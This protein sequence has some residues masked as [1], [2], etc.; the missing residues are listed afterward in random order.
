MTERVWAGNEEEDPRY[1]S[2]EN[3][4]EEEGDLGAGA[5]CV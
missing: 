5:V 3:E 4:R 2:S 1:K